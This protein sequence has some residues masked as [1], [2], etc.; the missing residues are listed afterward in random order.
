MAVT[1]QHH[2]RFPAGGGA[3][4]LHGGHIDPAPGQGVGHLGNAAGGVLVVDDQGVGVPA[5]V[6]ADPI[7]G[8]DPDP[9]A[10]HR[11][12]RQAQAAVLPFQ[13]QDRRVGM[14]C[15][16]LHRM[17]LKL[18]PGL[19][20]QGETVGQAGIVRLH[21]QQP[22]HNGPVGAVAPS[23]GGKTAVQTDIGPDGLL[24]QQLAGG[25]TNPGGTRCMAGGRADHHRAQYVK[26][27]HCYN[28]LPFLLVT[29]NCNFIIPLLAY[30]C[31]NNFK[32]TILRP[33]GAARRVNSTMKLVNVETPEKNVCKMTFSAS[34]AELE[35]ASEAV[36]QRTRD[37]F[38][39]KGFAKGQADRAQIEADRGEHVFWY[40][41]IN[42][43]MDRDVP[44]LYEK[45]LTDHNM[46]PVD[47]PSYDLVSVKKDEGFV[48]TATVALQPQL[49]L[50]K[51][52]GFEV[53]ATIPATTDKEVDR[54]IER[55]RA[56]FAELVPHKGP[57]VKGNTVHMD[58]TGYLNGE[59]FPNGSA[60]NQ[61]IELG[62]GRMIPGFEEGIIG[63]QAGDEFDMKV[64]FPANYHAKDLAGKEATFKVK[65]HD[66]CVRQLPALNSDFAKKAGKVDT[67][68]AYRAQIHDQ[69]AARKRTT[70]LNRARNQ[71]IAMLAEASK[72]DLPGILVENA[73]HQEMQSIQQQLQMQRLSL[74]KYL[75]QVHQTR[76]EFKAT[77]RKM[78]E[79]NARARMAL[80]QIAGDENLIPTDAELDAQLAQRA[81]MAKK[82]LESIKAKT[83]LRALRR[84]DAI[85]KAA[86]WVFAH[87]TINEKQA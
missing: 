48:A 81:E 46:T 72:G 43:L 26:Q 40:D 2:H 17:N 80:L 85:R 70:A 57:A 27:A 54:L 41:A 55:R 62:R 59:P 86:D 77:V 11:G 73:Y 37:T 22:R 47:E 6:G 21:A 25:P 71:I 15:P 56:G 24:S 33:H 66:V 67:M 28:T 61:A 58:Y 31:Y 60:Q 53:T 14:G 64:T 35:E 12:R 65:I 50:E 38:T 36:Y 30:M 51:T 16:Q 44:D 23:G 49:E 18:H 8:G 52:S 75:G 4:H 5:E 69:L 79:Q 7:D 13:G 45:A 78:A 83:D 29:E 1:F 39:I 84:N 34:A 3:E 87:S 76:D 20:G 9:A 74:D 19:P 32:L 63:H 10:P 42:D 68:E 82:S